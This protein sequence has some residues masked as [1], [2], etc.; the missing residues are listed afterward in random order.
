MTGV[1]NDA[2]E[3]IGS[4]DKAFVGKSDVIPVERKK[5]GS[6]SARSGVMSAENFRVVTE[7]VNRKVKEIGTDILEG[8]IPMNPYTEGQI[9][10]CTYCPYTKVC[11]FD[12]KLPGFTMRELEKLDDMQALER[13]RKE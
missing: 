2:D 7:Y 1:V 10:S 3:V 11:G 8:K 5:D 13:M 6:Y 4:L 9:S 12:K